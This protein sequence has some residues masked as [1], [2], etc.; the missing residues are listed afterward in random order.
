MQVDFLM[1][2]ATISA[3]RAGRKLGVEDMGLLEDWEELVENRKLE[4]K[5]NE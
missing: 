5:S 1:A 4:E 2:M 3:L